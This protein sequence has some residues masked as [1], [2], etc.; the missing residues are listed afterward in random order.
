MFAGLSAALARVRGLRGLVT[1]PGAISLL[2]LGLAIVVTHLDRAVARYSSEGFGLLLP[3]PAENVQPLLTAIAGSTMT[4]LTLV[5][6]SVLVV[7]TLAAGTLGPRLLM[8]F[9][10]DRMNQVAVGILGATFLYC[11]VA[12]RN[13]SADD[14]GQWTVNIAVGLAAT[15]VLVLL[16][17]INSA[18]R[19]VTID[20]EIGQIS[21]TLDSE[22]DRAIGESHAIDPSA[23]VRPHGEEF[24]VTAQAK[25]YINRIDFQAIATVA[26]Q[27]NAFVDFD[28]RPGI[29]VVQ[30]ERIASVIG[31]N[32]AQ[33]S[34]KIHGVIVCG[35][36]RTT[37]DDL[38]FS[39]NLLVEIGLRAL[40]PGVNDTF[41]AI[42]CAD[43]LAGSLL[44][45]RRAGLQTGVYLDHAGVARVTAPPVAIGQLIETAF[46][47]LRRASSDNMLMCRNLIAALGTLGQGVG[48]PGEDEVRRQLDLVR[49]EFEASHALE[50][51]KDAI[52]ELVRHTLAHRVGRQLLE[53]AIC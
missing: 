52:R 8:R 45:A 2:G 34:P 11:L 28:V 30:G 14:P 48:L 47:P 33:L 36:R 42:A 10:Q 9:A 37:A 31:R 23:I 5:Y 40:S 21:K 49:A 27:W 41:T 4:A 25:G 46:T 16:F 53:T 51:D 22:L 44:R 12:L 15:C 39:I 18:A 13:H 7:F 35:E 38:N 24:A 20:E 50:A 43:R 32:G 19:K 3:V 17:F 1:I 26:E 29:F 6:S